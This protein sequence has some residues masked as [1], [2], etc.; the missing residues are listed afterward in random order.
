MYNKNFYY[1]LLTLAQQDLGK[2][3]LHQHFTTARSY[4]TAFG[5]SIDGTGTWSGQKNGDTLVYNNGTITGTKQWVSGLELCDWMVTR[6]NTSNDCVFV[7]IDKKDIIATPVSTQG[8]EGTL[9][10]HFTC[11][12][13]PVRVLGSLTD[14]GVMPVFLG[15]QWGFITN[16]L[17]LSMAAYKDINNYTKNIAFEYTKNKI[18]LDLEVFNLLWTNQV[19]NKSDQPWQVVYAFAKKVLAQIVQLTTELTGNG[20]YETNLPSHQRFQDM[21]IYSVHMCNTS[22]AIK[23][24]TNWCV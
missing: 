6:V 16:Q 13:A 20:L 1:E 17:G 23:N 15:H 19:D 5:S 12:Q 9:T 14:P 21:L 2:A 22:V 8:M 24:I 4:V 10:V 3:H 18:R 11:N 7:I